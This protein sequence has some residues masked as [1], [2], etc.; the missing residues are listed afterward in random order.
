MY[1]AHNIP[2]PPIGPYSSPMPRDLGGWVFLMNGVPLSHT[3]D[4]GR[5]TTSPA[6]QIVSRRL[7]SQNTVPPGGLTVQ[8]AGLT[9][10]LTALGSGR[11]L[12]RGKERESERAR[13]I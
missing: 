7:V 3:A 11:Q 8:G 1:L 10:R 9:D 2:P 12:A 13:E 4:K 5:T 6:L